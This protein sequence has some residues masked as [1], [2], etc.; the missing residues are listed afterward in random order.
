[1]ETTIHPPIGAVT[2]C[3]RCGECC[4]RYAI[5]VL[6][7]ELEVEARFLKLDP[8]AFTL[9]Y[10]KLLVQI[11]PFSSA[12]HPLALHTSMIPKPI[13]EKL[14]AAGFD[15]QYA[16][17]LPMLGFKKEEYC[18]FFDPKSF[19]CTI[20]PVKPKQCRLF[21]FTSLKDNED[22]SKAY[23]FCELAAI[24]SPTAHTKTEQDS[25]KQKLRNYFDAVGEKG[26]ERVWKYLPAEGDLIYP[27]YF[28]QKITLDELKQLLSTAKEK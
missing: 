9:L 6:P 13:W 12:N 4:K 18:V 27:G 19:G 1:M 10:T 11:M 2:A 25:Q 24:T 28:T 7:D 14:K 15:A 16:M 26:L 3:A 22:Y 5:S 23:D 8:R 21:P 20:H 17:I